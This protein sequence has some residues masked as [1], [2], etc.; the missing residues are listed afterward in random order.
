MPRLSIRNGRNFADQNG[1]VHREE[2]TCPRWDESSDCFDDCPV[3]HGTEKVLV[4]RFPFELWYRPLRG[5]FVQRMLM[6]VTAHNFGGLCYRQELSPSTCL[7]ALDDKS[8]DLEELMRELDDGPG[9]R[10]YCLQ[11]IAEFRDICA[12]AVRRNELLLYEVLPITT[13]EG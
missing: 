10:D 3:C 8:S 5:L 11:T 7:E 4:E 12:E 1:L 2:R 6:L 13:A 9:W